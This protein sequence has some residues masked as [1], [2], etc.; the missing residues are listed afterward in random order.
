MT[1]RLVDE[2]AAALAAAL[3]PVIERLEELERRLDERG[4]PEWL[5]LEQAAERLA[6]TAGALRWRAQ[7]GRLPGAVKDEGRWLVDRR[8]LDAA[9]A[10]DTVARTSKRGHAPRERPCP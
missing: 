5:T 1:D 8:R 2:L 9:L 4:A 10:G 3:G 6:T 7:H